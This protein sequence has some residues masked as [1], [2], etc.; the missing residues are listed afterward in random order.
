MSVK[1]TNLD[2]RLTQEA[3]DPYLPQFTFTCTRNPGPEPGPRQRSQKLTQSP[4][5]PELQQNRSPHPPRQSPPLISDIQFTWSL[6]HTVH[7]DT[8]LTSNFQFRFLFSVYLMTASSE[9]CTESAKQNCV[10]LSDDLDRISGPQG[11]LDVLSG[12]VFFRLAAFDLRVQLAELAK[13]A[14]FAPSPNPGAKL[15]DFAAPVGRTQKGGF[16]IGRRAIIFY[17]LTSKRPP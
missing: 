10:L 16:H 11:S 8:P 4:Q 7:P 9:Q 3:S 12:V 1:S 17:R 6:P 15:C 14:D 2:F 13:M 5:N